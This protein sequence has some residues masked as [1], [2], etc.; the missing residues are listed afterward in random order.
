[1]QEGILD[2]ENNNNEENPFDSM[3]NDFEKINAKAYASKMN[4]YPY[5]VI[6]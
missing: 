6:W 2:R 5:L 1:M 3:I 4:N